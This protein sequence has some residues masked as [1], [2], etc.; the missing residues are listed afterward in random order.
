MDA[1]RLHVLA[2]SV[3]AHRRVSPAAAGSADTSTPTKL[4]LAGLG[5]SWTSGPRAGGQGYGR[6]PR[7]V[8]RRGGR[9]VSAAVP[10]DWAE[11]RA[12]WLPPGGVPWGRWPRARRAQ[13]DPALRP[14]WAGTRVSRRADHGGAA[15][16]LCC[17]GTTRAP[18]CST[19]AG[20]PSACPTTPCPILCPSAT[21]SH[22][23][24]WGRVNGSGRSGCPNNPPLADPGSC[25]TIQPLL[26]R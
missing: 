1:F 22:G 17:P 11:R 20:P 10:L 15:P 26:P 25:P 4:G 2:S 14:G 8:W 16:A 19:G 9:P 5:P 23:R 13:P 7:P 24:P 12:P 3:V 21:P 18:P 6:A